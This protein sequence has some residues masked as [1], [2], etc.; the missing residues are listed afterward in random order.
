LGPLPDVPGDGVSTKSVAG[1]CG[2]P[3]GASRWIRRVSS[4]FGDVAVE[5]VE[6]VFEGLF[7]LGGGVVFRKLGFES[8]DV[9]ELVEV[10]G[11]VGI[12]NVGFSL[13]EGFCGGRGLGAEEA[14]F[15]EEVA[16]QKTGKAR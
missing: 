10:E 15:E 6:E 5:S 13:V 11:L 3:P 2:P 1:P 8:L 12:G 9:R 14:G 7:E 16:Q 4:L